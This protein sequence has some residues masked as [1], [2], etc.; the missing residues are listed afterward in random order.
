MNKTIIFLLLLIIPLTL[1]TYVYFTQPEKLPNL[2]SFTPTPTPIPSPVPTAV[3]EITKD[4]FVPQTIRVVKGTQVTWINQDTKPHWVISDPHPTHHTLST[5][6]SGQAL[7]PQDSFSYTFES[8]G[9]FSYHDELNPL[10][11]LGEVVVE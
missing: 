1:G 8:Q 7:M 5:L 11:I 2:P 6:N 4:G 10:K 9:T 3:V